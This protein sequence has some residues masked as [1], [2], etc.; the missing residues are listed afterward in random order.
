M[1]VSAVA[2]AAMSGGPSLS[3]GTL[4]QLFFDAVERH[5]KPNAL[6]AKAG[7]AYQP[8][9]HRALLER[10]RRVA[11]GLRALG[12]VRGGGE[13]VLPEN[14][15]EWA[16]V[17]YA[18]LTVGITDVPLYPTLP[19]EQMTYVLRDSGAVLIFVSNEEQARKIASIRGQLPALRYVIG[20]GQTATKRVDM[21]LR[22]LEA[23]GA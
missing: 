19:A 22:T 21:T 4:N 20:F 13:S 2:Q 8:I 7:G 17:D 14:R 11:L 23:K 10:V 3:P 12:L 5:D 15:P 18:C 1:T 6:Q 9:S 16:I